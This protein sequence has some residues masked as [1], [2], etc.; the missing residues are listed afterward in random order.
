[1]ER[2]NEIGELVTL[3]EFIVL[4]RPGWEVHPRT[5]IPRLRLRWCEGHLVE[6]SST[7]IRERVRTGRPVD[8]MIPHKTIEYMRETGLYRA[9]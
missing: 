7:E 2:R 4:A 8:F 5:D 6:F 3:V 9:L 1:V